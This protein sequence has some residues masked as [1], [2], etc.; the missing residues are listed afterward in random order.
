MAAISHW[1]LYDAFIECTCTYLT[2]C[3][4]VPSLLWWMS[5]GHCWCTTS[6][7][8]S[9]LSRNPMLT[10]WPGTHSMRSVRLDCGQLYTIGDSDEHVTSHTPHTPR[11]HTLHPPPQYTHTHTP[12][13][14]PPPPHT[15]THTHPTHAPLQDMLCFSGNGMMSIKASNFPAHQRKQQV[16]CVCWQLAWLL[17][18]HIHPVML[19]PAGVCGWVQWL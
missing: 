13:T 2:H 10:V 5:M 11:T 6:A 17:Y 15:H 7:T 9:C 18:F 16:C 3:P 4:V 12:Y 14:P 8:R 19:W 1:I